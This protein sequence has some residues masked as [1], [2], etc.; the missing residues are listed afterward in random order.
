MV[1]WLYRTSLETT[2]LIG[3]VLILRPIV[4]RQLGAHVSYWLWTLPVIR[5]FLWSKPEIPI[6]VMERMTLPSGEILLRIF[7]NPA[8]FE[9]PL[10]IPFE[11]MWLTGLSIWS[12]LRIAGW[13]RLQRDL[14]EN[15]SR[16]DL[17]PNLQHFV[18][19]KGYKTRLEY[20]TTNMPSA[21]FVTG[22]FK[23]KIYLP[24]QFFGR[25]S[26]VQQQCILAHEL[27]H[28][29]RKDLWLQVVG[30]LLKATFWFN[31]IIHIAWI[32]FREDQELA[33]DQ[34][35][36]RHSSEMERYEYGRALVKGLHAHLLPATLAFF[37]AK[38]ERFVM[39]EK[40]KNSLLH[41]VIGIGLCLLIAVFA[42]TKA[43]Q[44]IAHSETPKSE[45][46][47]LH[48][49]DIPLNILISRVFIFAKKE[50]VGLKLLA[51]TLVTVDIKG[52][53]ALNVAKVVLNCYGFNLKNKDEIYE[54]VKVNSMGSSNS[55]DSKQCV[56]SKF[57]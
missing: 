18:I 28:I 47:S 2:V 49:D 31:P 14:R 35:V 54:I 42:L 7:P 27:T 3:I 19:S 16:I 12:M 40:H 1:D 4:R 45:E 6:A 39:L 22:L 56:D 25:Y 26:K 52:V 9:I 48:F 30:E 43:P 32:A 41:N 57:K 36:L 37:N 46:I 29:K 51:D 10:N 21:P 44:S 17:P 8:H 15:S 20:F 50:V 55:H 5:C 11:W 33:C 53:A 23:P 38:K 34:Q 13:Q 24:Y